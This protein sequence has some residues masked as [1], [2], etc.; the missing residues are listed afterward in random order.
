MSAVQL[1][2]LSETFAQPFRHERRLRR[3]LQALCEQGW[4]HR[5]VRPSASP[6]APPNYYT[7]SAEGYR[8]VHGHDEPLP[9]P[10]RFG[11][12]A[13]SRIEH[14]EALSDFIVHAV[15][16]AHRSRLLV[17]AFWRENENELK[18]SSTGESLYPDATF[19]LVVPGGR[20]FLFY[21][22]VDNGSERVRSV[23]EV[24]SFA[25]KARF[26]ERLRDS[27]ERFRVL[28]TTTGGIERLQHMLDTAKVVAANP[29]RPLVYGATLAEYLAHPDP[30]LGTCF[31]DHHGRPV[32]P[33]YI[34]KDVP[35]VLLQTTHA[36][37][38]AAC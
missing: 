32:A 15:V 34:P 37:T 6:G 20:V 27:G 4:V 28:V 36:L 11:P 3:R 35:E 24:D 31:R 14:T 19:E 9:H 13:F 33:A 8:Y 12:M 1:L 2:K 18:L 17:G 30:M 38:A 23:K 21:V 26:Y 10:R 22:E 7:L 29:N 16:S 5:W 25:R